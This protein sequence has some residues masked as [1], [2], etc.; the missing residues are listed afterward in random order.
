MEHYAN[1]FSLQ[2]ER[3]F[4]MIK[5]G[6]GTGDAQHCPYLHEWRGRSQDTVGKWHTAEACNGHRADL[7]AVQRIRR[8]QPET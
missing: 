4:R 3:C 2:S 5:V 8:L 1:C 7:D 6:D